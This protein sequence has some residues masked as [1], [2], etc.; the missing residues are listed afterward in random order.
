MMS[1]IIMCRIIKSDISIIVQCDKHDIPA[2]A[3]VSQKSTYN[4]APVVTRKALLRGKSECPTELKPKT[5]ST[6][7]F[8]VLTHYNAQTGATPETIII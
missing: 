5:K 2:D 4:Q 3:R 7:V 1:V 6:I 8:Y